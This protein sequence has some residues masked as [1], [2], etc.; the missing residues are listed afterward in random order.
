MHSGPTI[1]LRLPAVQAKTGIKAKST[2]YGMIA[3]GQFPKPRKLTS[4]AVGWLASDI[5]AWINSRPLAA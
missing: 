5:D 4:R 2:L 1:V 3:K